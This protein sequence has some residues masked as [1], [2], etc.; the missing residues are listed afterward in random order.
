[1]QVLQIAQEYATHAK[2]NQFYLYHIPHEIAVMCQLA[3]Y[4]YERIRQ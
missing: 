4:A 3:F 1:M 2:Q